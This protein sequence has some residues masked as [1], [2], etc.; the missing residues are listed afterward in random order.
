MG[1]LDF[2]A[3]GMKI[4][5]PAS[6]DEIVAEGNALRHCVASYVDKVA[7]HKTMI[8]FL[9]RCE[10]VDKP[11][12]TVEVQHRKVVQVRGNCNAAPTPEVRKFMD[13]WERRVLRGCDIE[14]AA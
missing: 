7:A 3:N 12:F 5:Y 8:L 6:S 4:V 11:F 2:E 14:M 9:R 10:D 13:V 1:Q